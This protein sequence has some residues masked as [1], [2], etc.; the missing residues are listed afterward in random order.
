MKRILFSLFVGLL[1]DGCSLIEEERKNYQWEIENSISMYQFL[2]NDEL[3]N[4]KSY[5]S[6]EYI[7][8]I[9]CM[10]KNQRLRVRFERA[11]IRCTDD[12]KLI[13]N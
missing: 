8:Y 4:G 9:A 3:E 5:K 13:K 10:E 1:L 7:N 6:M 2:L 11:K 12:N